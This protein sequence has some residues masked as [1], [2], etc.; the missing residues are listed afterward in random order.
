MNHKL[1]ANGAPELWAQIMKRSAKNLL[2]ESD[3]VLK[4]S[5]EIQ[6]GIDL[7]NEEYLMRVLQSLDDKDKPKKTELDVN[8]DFVRDK[9]T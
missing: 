4:E 9:I 1:S 6:E 8:K 3:Q 7:Q 2:E 5:K